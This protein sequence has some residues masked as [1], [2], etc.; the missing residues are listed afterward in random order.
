MRCRFF[1]NN[2]SLKQD[3]VE[4]KRNNIHITKLIY[5]KITQEFIAN[6]LLSKYSSFESI[7]YEIS[8]NNNGIP[9]RATNSDDILILS[10][11]QIFYWYVTLIPLAR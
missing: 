5:V 11:Q 10:K 3:E 6:L 8:I 1:F 4:K 2:V 9:Q 7:T